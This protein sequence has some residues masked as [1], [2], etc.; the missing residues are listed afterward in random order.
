MLAIGGQEL[1]V[2]TPLPCDN[3]KIHAKQT[4]KIAMLA[5]ICYQWIWSKSVCKHHAFAVSLE[6]IIVFLQI[7]RFVRTKPGTIQ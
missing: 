6:F 3:K 2:I 1:L 5:G 7:S 4:T